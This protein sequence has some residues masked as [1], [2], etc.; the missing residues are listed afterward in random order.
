MA[1]E[2]GGRSR[3]APCPM[4]QT[5]RGSLLSENTGGGRRSARGCMPRKRFATP[6]AQ[7]LHVAAGVV[8]LPVGQH[9]AA[10]GLWRK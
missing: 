4:Y 2:P 7:I 3:P 9:D 5:S 1:S 6:W 8:E 10:H